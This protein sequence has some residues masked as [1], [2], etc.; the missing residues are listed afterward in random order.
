MKESEIHV[1]CKEKARLTEHCAM[2]RAGVLSDNVRDAVSEKIRSIVST[3]HGIVS[4][5]PAGSAA[6]S[7]YA[8][9]AS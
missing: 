3:P 4:T 9:G 2:Q 7:T 5:H 8:V 1:R 6:T